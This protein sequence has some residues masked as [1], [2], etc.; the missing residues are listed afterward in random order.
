R[1]NKRHILYHCTVIVLAMNLSCTTQSPTS[2]PVE[3]PTAVSTALASSTPPSE[4]TQENAS[5]ATVTAVIAVTGHLMKPA[6]L[7]PKPGNLIYDVESSGIAAP[8]GDLF[9]LNRL[10]RPFLADMTYVSDMDITS[11]NLSEDSDWY[12]VSIELSGNDP[13]NSIGIN[14]GVEIDLDFDGFGDYILWSQ[15]PY[16]TSWETTN[17]KVFKDSDHDS[18]GLSGTQSDTG[19]GGNGY[20]ELVFDGEGGQNDDPD[21]AWVRVNTEPNAV[22]QFVFKKSLVGSFFMLGVVSDAGLKDISKFDYNDSFEEAEAGSPDKNKAYYP[23]GSL[24]GV[25]NTCWEA[26][27]IQTTGYEPKLCQPILQP[28]PTF[29]PFQPLQP[30]IPTDEGFDCIPDVPPDSCGFDEETGAPYYNPATCT[31]T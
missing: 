10:E 25:D 1:M 28:T 13:N 30:S 18:A 9:K 26:Y 4:A 6:E 2:L 12:Y 22:V 24:Y 20:D 5:V 11:F 23:L 7:A 27:G 14:Y 17:L 29:Q 31:C 19:L 21:L 8:Y 16:S 3:Q 15:P